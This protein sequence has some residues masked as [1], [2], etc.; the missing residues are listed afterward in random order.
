MTTTIVPRSDRIDLSLT[1]LT[2]LSH[3]DAAEQTDSNR[4]LFNRERMLVPRAGTQRP[5][6]QAEVDAVC[7]FHPVPPDVVPL[8][9]DVTFPEF[10]AVAVTRLW[11]DAYNRGD[12]VGL[13][14]GVERYERV[15]ARLRQAAIQAASLRGVWDRLCA[16]MQVPLHPTELDE[17]VC[18][19]LALP[20]AV[21]QLVIRALVEQTRST[22]QLARFWHLTRK[23]QSATYAERSGQDVATAG[24]V[25]L[26]FDAATIASTGT[27]VQVLEV[28]KL[29]GNSVRHQ[30]VRAPAWWRLH[31]ALGLDPTTPGGGGL[32]AGVEAL[33]VNGGNI[34]AGAQQPTNPFALASQIR[35]TFPSLDLL[36]G[37]VDS[38]DLGES[39]LKVA[40]WIV[41]RENRAAL[42]GTPLADAD[43]ATVSVFDLLDDVTHT[44]Q[45]TGRG[46]GQMIY[47][48]QTL[49]A[50]TQL[51][52]R[53]SLDPGTPALTRGALA[54]AVADYLDA[55]ATMGGQ[56]ARGFGA[57]RGTWLGDRARWHDDR[58]AYLAHLAAHADALRDALVSGRLGTPR[59]LLS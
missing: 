59:P 33:F 49:C 30:L 48:F 9:E 16:T 43:A 21:Q 50:G 32:P 52:V 1:A 58:G 53:L 17:T 2:A 18:R 42:D 47:S 37:V 24:E 5:P 23:R 6:T 19:S 13:L 25:Q 44:R 26:R 11:L 45:A 20:S 51:Y 29:S 57:L 14:T 3:H 38:F 27:G 22:V 46:V 34:A 12:G 56:A 28:P 8:F 36:G 54:Q 39:R 55:D 40:C 35:A 31:T 41:C 4:L 7:A 15:E 10:A